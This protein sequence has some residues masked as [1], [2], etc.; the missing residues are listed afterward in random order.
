MVA[1][2]ITTVE[3]NDTSNARRTCSSCP[4]IE[5]SIRDFLLNVHVDDGGAEV[6]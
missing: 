1:D 6:R 5:V 3:G 4:S 2:E